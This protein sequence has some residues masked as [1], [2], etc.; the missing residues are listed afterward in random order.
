MP[1]PGE[2]RRANASDELREH[3]VD[4]GYTHLATVFNGG[5]LDAERRTARDRYA[6]RREI[7]LEEVSGVGEGQSARSTSEESDKDRPIDDAGPF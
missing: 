7:A 4:T 2:H 3:A 6:R 5:A 1:T